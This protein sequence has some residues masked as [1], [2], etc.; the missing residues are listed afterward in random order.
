[1]QQM[2]HKCCVLL[3]KTFESF[4]RGF[5]HREENH[6]DIGTRLLDNAAFVRI[7]IMERFSK[8]FSELRGLRYER[9]CKPSNLSLNLRE[10]VDNR[11]R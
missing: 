5:T 3:G 1:M 2:I 11:F 9:K 4:D 6:L 7:H 8:D 10:H